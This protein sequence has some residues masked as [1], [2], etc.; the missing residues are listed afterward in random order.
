MQVNTLTIT[1]V[2]FKSS[3][4]FASG[5]MEDSKKRQQ[6]AISVVKA[7]RRPS[8]YCKHLHDFILYHRDNFLTLDIKGGVV[9]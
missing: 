9:K 2:S 3:G 8:I 4:I 7:Q 1:G 5:Q 6:R